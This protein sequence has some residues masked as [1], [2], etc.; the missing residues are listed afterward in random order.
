MRIT[1]N[2]TLLIFAEPNN[3]V[4]SPLKNLDFSALYCK[5]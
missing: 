2:F 3:D 4:N 1:E 5:I